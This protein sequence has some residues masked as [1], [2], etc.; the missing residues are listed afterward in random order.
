VTASLPQRDAV[1]F[2]ASLRP[3]LPSSAALLRTGAVALSADEFERF[4][5]DTCGVLSGLG[6]SCAHTLN[7]VQRHHLAHSMTGLSNVLSTALAPDGFERFVTDTCDT[8]GMV[9][10]CVCAVKNA[11][12]NELLALLSRSK[13]K[14][15]H[16][17]VD[18]NQLS[19]S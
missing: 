18:D 10:R 2:L 5:T 8:W 9:V 4:V 11:M 12:Q 13:P 15:G 3:Y 19:Q 7:N 16:C 1:Q 17:R 6:V 14:V